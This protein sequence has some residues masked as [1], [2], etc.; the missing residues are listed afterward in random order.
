M[1]GS[2]LP[3]RASSVRSRPVTTADLLQGGEHGFPVDADAVG[4]REQQVFG[5][6]VLVTHV[7]PGAVAVVEHGLE[8]TRQ[9]G[10][11]TEGLWQ[12]RH[13]LVGGVADAQRWATQ[14]VEDGEDH[15]LLLAQ[16]RRQQVVRGHLGIAV[17]LGRVDGGRERLLGLQRPAVRIQRHAVSLTPI[18]PK[19]IVTLSTLV[20][21]PA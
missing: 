12:A 7:D 21:S 17:L 2:S 20:V 16:Q 10:L 14:P 4:E 19:L 18:P 11:A 3:W 9:A 13:R 8:L 6:Q 1:T 15:T 5:R